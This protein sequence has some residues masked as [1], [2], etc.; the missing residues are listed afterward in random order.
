MLEMK[1][2]S[3]AFGAVQALKNASFQIDKGEIVAL[4][5]ANGSGKST[6]IKILGGSVRHG[7]GTIAI[8]G[9]EVKIHSSELSRK[10]KIAVAYQ[11]LSLLPLMSVYENVMLGH[12]KKGKTGRIDE[13]A[14]KAYVASLFQKFDIT[15]DLNDYPADLPPSTLSMIEIV[16]AISWNPDI[17]LLDEVTA[18]LHHTEVEL[19]FKNLK[20]LAQAGTSIVVVTHRLGEIYRIASRAV[21]LRNGES[22]A[23]VD[24]SETKIDSVVYHMTGKMPETATHSARS[25]EHEAADAVLYVEDLCI[26]GY[27]NNA[28]MSVKKGE[29]I[30]LG[31]LEGQGQS[32][33]LRALYGANPY[34]SGKVVIRGKTVKYTNAADAVRDGIGFISGDRNRESVFAQRAIGENIYS[35]RLAQ[36]GDIRYFSKRRVNR[37]TQKMVSDLDIKIG[38]INNPISSLSGGNQQKVVFGRWIFITP[39]ILLL[40]DPTKGVD[41]MTR[42]EMHK[43]LRSI[44][45]AG[46]T[47]LMVSSDNDEL[48]EVSDRIYVFFEGNIHAVLEGDSRTEEQ[49]VSAMLGLK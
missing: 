31:G 10:L 14:N 24:L 20:E 39:Q 28:T 2:I 26:N 17:L 16:K 21:I 25:T 49:L 15:C 42:R 18:T 7:S 22:V 32:Q 3:K 8:N 19:L 27:V 30:G 1:N 41:V 12:F 45:D 46:T 11:E 35:A 36:K 47:V 38:N 13:K 34:N 5:G 44:S 29:I 23:D 6:L 48:L 33:F 37:T 4:L 43:I 40:D 9:K